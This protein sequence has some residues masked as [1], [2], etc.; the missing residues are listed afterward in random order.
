M[1]CQ[2]EQQQEGM[3]GPMAMWCPTRTTSGTA[4]APWIGY[5]YRYIPL[6]VCWIR[7]ILAH[8]TRA[9]PSAKIDL[10]GRGEDSG[11]RMPRV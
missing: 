3:A 2:R 9:L 6:T 10:P 1:H 5:R 4:M 8:H 11:S 7:W